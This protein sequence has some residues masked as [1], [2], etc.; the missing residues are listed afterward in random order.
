MGS[1]PGILSPYLSRHPGDLTQ[2]G[3]GFLTLGNTSTYTLAVNHPAHRNHVLHVH[4]ITIEVSIVG[5]G[6]GS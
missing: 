4:F 1:A 3:P 2:L 5:R 6:A